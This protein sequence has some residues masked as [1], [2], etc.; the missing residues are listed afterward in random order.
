MPG[1]YHTYLIVHGLYYEFAASEPNHL[2][3]GYTRH[4]LL[5]L[6]LVYL[7]NIFL[8]QILTWF[9]PVLWT[10]LRYLGPERKTWSI[11]GV[12]PNKLYLQKALKRVR[13]SREYD[14]VLR[15]HIMILLNLL[16]VRKYCLSEVMPGKC[17]HAWSYPRAVLMTAIL[18][19]NR[20]D[21]F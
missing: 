6:Y 2:Y 21:I 3:I 15:C 4:I 16:P 12:I 7:W 14:T 17:K 19:F 13:D 1:I 11:L 5:F 8:R 10:P 20:H 9:I 18:K